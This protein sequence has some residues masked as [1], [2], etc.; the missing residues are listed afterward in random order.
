MSMLSLDCEI[1]TLAC[2]SNGGSF[3]RR[4]SIL[5]PAAKQ[6]ADYDIYHG[7]SSSDV[8][9][10]DGQSSIE[11]WRSHFGASVHGHKQ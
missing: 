1:V 10:F 3:I 7:N 2:N 8:F 6:G 11:P 4:E 5:P 9:D